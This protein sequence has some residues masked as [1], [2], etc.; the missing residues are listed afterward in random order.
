MAVYRYGLSLAAGPY[1]PYHGQCAVC[2][3]T[4]AAG[5]ISQSACRF[6]HSRYKQRRGLGVACVM[7]MFG[8]GLY[9]GTL[10][11]AGFAA[12]FAAALLGALAVTFVMLFLSSFIRNNA[13]LLI[14]GVMLGYITSSVVMLLNFFA[15]ADGVER[16]CNGEWA[17][18][19]EFQK[20][21]CL[22]I[23]FCL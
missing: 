4:H 6:F 17:I 3:R 18:S 8:G 10:S 1:S 21:C 11:V 23:L 9:I 16:M 2:L 20:R 22:S 5:Y 7:L 13:L 12:V 14:A 19:L 15:S